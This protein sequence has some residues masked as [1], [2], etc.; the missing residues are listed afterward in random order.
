MRTGIIMWHKAHAKV[1]LILDLG[2]K[3]SSGR[4]ETNFIMQEIELCDLVSVEEIGNK[5]ILIECDDPSVPLDEKNLCHKAV[6]IMQ[7]IGEKNN[8]VK[9]SIKKKTPNAGGFGGGSSDAAVVANIL[10]DTWNMGLSKDE[11]IGRLNP[12]LGTDTSFFIKGGTASVRSNGLEVNE[13]NTNI[14]LHYVFIV[15][16]INLPSGK[17]ESVYA[18]FNPEKVNKKSNIDKMRDA[19]TTGNIKEISNQLYNAFE[20][21]LPPWYSEIP[22]IKKELINAGCIN[23]IMCGAG[24]TVFGTCANK[25]EAQKI[26]NKL[27]DKHSV[28]FTSHTRG[29][30]DG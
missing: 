6:K 22:K 2:A 17:T 4:F 24:P 12:A 14:D 9:I 7:K 25:E 20:Y 28:V 21:S 30:I 3:N 5:Q 8:G 18:Y 23:A 15:P 11:L 27:A 13:I 1:N 10:N 29:A 19:L 16:E 26:A